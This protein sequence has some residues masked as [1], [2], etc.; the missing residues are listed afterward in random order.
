MH[1]TM[2]TL[3]IIGAIVLA[4][5][6]ILCAGAIASADGGIRDG[7]N[8]LTIPARWTRGS[9]G[10]YHFQ[11]SSGTAHASETLTYTASAP[12]TELRVGTAAHD[13]RLVP[14]E[15]L[16][17]VR[18]T[19]D[20]TRD[21]QFKITEENGCLTFQEIN[22]SVNVGFD[23]SFDTANGRVI[24]EYPAAQII[25]TLKLTAVSGDIRCEAPE[26]GAVTFST[27]SGDI[28]TAAL[29]ADSFTAGTVSGGME[30]GAVSAAKIELSSTSGDMKWESLAADTVK[31]SSISGAVK[32]AL[33]AA[34]LTASTTS[35]DIRLDADCGSLDIGTISGEVE[36]ELAPAAYR[37]QLS[38]VS[39]DVKISGRHYDRKDLPFKG[40]FTLEA[41]GE[42]TSG[43]P[44]GA[45]P[46]SISTT[47]GDMTIKVD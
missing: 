29:Q 36:L 7:L 17:T 1:K 30:L 28:R 10:Q 12:V 23:L 47:S 34:E 3:A 42:I 39:G 24:V 40:R 21:D 20:Q 11:A 15:S 4:L 35:G 19:Y 26:A 45:R 38:T 41:N 43:T 46:L 13:I 22:S 37:A 9:D 5:G 32:G 33:R 44:E 14:S 27:T 2:K 18:I 6:L 25:R 31:V 16:S 8:W